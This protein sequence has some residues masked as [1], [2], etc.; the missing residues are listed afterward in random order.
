MEQA[1]PIYFHANVETI[2]L[3]NSGIRLRAFE[4]FFNFFD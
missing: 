2:R 4:T 1:H 3:C